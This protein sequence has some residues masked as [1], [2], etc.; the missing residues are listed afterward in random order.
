MVGIDKISRCFFVA[1]D[2][3]N[4]FLNENWR[5]VVREVQPVL[6]D[7]IAELFKSF[8]NKMFHMYP[9]DMLMPED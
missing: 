6:E 7:T 8:A 5:N 1:G 9:L 3:M 2:T 4:R